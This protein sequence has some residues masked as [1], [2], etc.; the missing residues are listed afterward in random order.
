M[1][2]GRVGRP[3]YFPAADAV[4]LDM[5]RWAIRWGVL[6]LGGWPATR[7]EGWGVGWE[8]GHTSVGGRGIGC[9]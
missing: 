9:G 8:L 6:R 3:P 5:A 4:Q 7:M 2:K 1:A